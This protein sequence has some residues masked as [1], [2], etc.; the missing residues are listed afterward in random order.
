MIN[1]SWLSKLLS[2]AVMFSFSCTITSS[3]LGL[4]K[5]KSSNSSYTLA[6]LTFT[7]SYT[8][9]FSTGS[10]WTSS[11]CMVLM[12]CSPFSLSHSV[13]GR[14]NSELWFGNLLTKVEQSKF[15]LKNQLHLEAPKHDHVH[16][17]T[18]ERRDVCSTMQRLQVL[19]EWVQFSY[20]YLL[21][22]TQNSPVA[23]YNMVNETS[24]LMRFL[25]VYTFFLELKSLDKQTTL[26]WEKVFWGPK[27]VVC[28]FLLGSHFPQGL[29]RPKI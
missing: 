8:Y 27:I 20:W 21:F 1:F 3:I 26:Q 6:P 12:D 9:S 5:V 4:A 28:S 25:W 7:A 15:M 13:S 23:S 22:Q 17:S 2:P 16:H 14:K 18:E 10:V 19:S 24:S 29:Q 11:A